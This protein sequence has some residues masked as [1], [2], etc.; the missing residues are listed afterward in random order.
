MPLAPPK[1]G[2]VKVIKT[3]EKGSDVN[4]ALYLLSDG[5][6]NAYDVA[7]IVSNDSD[8]LLPIQFAKKELGKKI[9]ILNPQKHPS[10]VLTAII[11]LIC[12]FMLSLLFGHVYIQE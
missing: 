6:K 12:A 8:L 2:Y 5:Y 10:K 1:N 9:G 3:E 11:V 4:L 7:V